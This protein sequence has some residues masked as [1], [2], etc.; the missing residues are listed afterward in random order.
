M[1]GQIINS[2]TRTPT[3]LRLV[4]TLGKQRELWKSEIRLGLK[5]LSELKPED[6]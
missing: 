3:S 2:L 4:K 5:G 1:A 6:R